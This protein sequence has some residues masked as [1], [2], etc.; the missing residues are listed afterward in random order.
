MEKLLPAEGAAEEE[1]DRRLVPQ[2][3]D[4]GHLVVELGRLDN[5]RG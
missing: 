1:A 5:V 2:V 3:R 4:V